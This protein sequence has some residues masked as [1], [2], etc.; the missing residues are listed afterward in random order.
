MDITIPERI[1]GD[2]I[3]GCLRPR[4]PRPPI[5]TSSTANGAPPAAAHLREHQ[6][7]RHARRRRPA[8]GLRRR[9]TSTRRSRRRRRR[10]PAGRPCP[11]RRAAR[12]SCKAAAILEA[13]LAEV[14]DILSREEGKTIGE[15]KG[16]VDA[17][18]RIL[19]YFGGEGARLSD[20]PSRRSGRA[21]SIY[22]DPR[23]PL[24]VVGLI[25]PWNFP[26][27]IPT[28]KMAP[29]LVSGNTVVFKPASWR[30]CWR[31]A[32]VEV[33]DEAGVPK[34]VLN[35][36]T[37]SGR[38]SA[39]RSSRTRECRRSRSP[40]RT[41][42]ATGSPS[43]ARS[44]GARAARDG[45][46]EPDDRAGRRRHGRRRRLVVN[47]AFFSTGQRCT[48]TSRAYRREGRS[49]TGSSSA[50]VARA[51]KLKVGDAL[52]AGIEH[53]PGRSTR[54]SSRRRSLSRHR[55]PG[56]R[57]AGPRR[58]AAADG[59]HAHGCFC[60]P[61]IYDRRRAAVRS[62]RR[63]RSSGRCSASSE[64]K[65]FDDAIAL[66]ND[67]RFGLSAAICTP[68]LSRARVRTAEAGMVMVNLPSAGVEYHIPFG[69]SKDSRS[70]WREQG[71]VATQ[72]FTDS[73]TVYINNHYPRRRRRAT[74]R[75]R[76]RGCVRRTG[77]LR[78]DTRLGIPCALQVAGAGKPRSRLLRREERRRTPVRRE[79]PTASR[80][81]CVSPLP[82]VPVSRRLAPVAL[83]ERP[84]R[85][86][87]GRRECK[88]EPAERHH[89]RPS[90]RS[91]KRVLLKSANYL[92]Q[93]ARGRSFST[94]AI[95]A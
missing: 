64:A 51:E 15:A 56:R 74:P 28:W 72:F 38:A 88:I 12:S 81:S 44:G 31:C 24:G 4:R 95:S 55:Q 70:G 35:L 63:R 65:D 57:D 62:S 94:T 91:P 50:L 8:A 33:L 90:F 59:A 89:T 83:Q 40:A 41:A 68:S 78:A 85:R 61:A 22:D 60:R 27:A 9:P 25:A 32:L 5:S 75:R 39:R 14:A 71:P 34:G 52:D 87:D 93:P 49:T 77:S 54:S 84:S 21:C 42:S 45:R 92:S 2:R 58:R 3:K 30:R 7:G 1:R 17:R 46:Q 36:V 47:A 82:S 6:P 67:V 66:A 13:R 73:K 37:G 26:I 19:E 10:S 79:I 23:E 86:I 18:R 11:R 53:R 80:A 29:A 76:D 43:A 48:A 20:R 16:E 69:G